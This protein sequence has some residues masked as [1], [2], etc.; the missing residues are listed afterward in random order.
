MN[1][2][3]SANITLTR[4]REIATEIAKYDL[5]DLVEDK[6]T[7]LLQDAYL[8]GENCWMFFRNTD[9]FIPTDHALSDCAYCVSKRGAARSIADFSADPTRLR[10]YLKTMSNHFQEQGL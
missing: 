8:E 10:E 2:D 7:P 6:A 9:I 4:A 5:Q 1:E 3:L